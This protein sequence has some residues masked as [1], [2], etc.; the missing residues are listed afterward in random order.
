MKHARDFTKEDWELVAA[1]ARLVLGSEFKAY[2]AAKYC[3]DHLYIIPEDA[4]NAWNDF[5]IDNPELRP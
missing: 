4:L 2:H 1:K 3:A 5:L